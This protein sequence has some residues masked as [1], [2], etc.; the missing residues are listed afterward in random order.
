M[1]Q[2]QPVAKASPAL[3]ARSLV[4]LVLLLSTAATARGQLTSCPKVSQVSGLKIMLD[5]VYVDASATS[6]VP[7]VSMDRLNSTVSRRLTELRA[8]L[9]NPPEIVLC[10]GRRPRTASDFVETQVDQLNARDV[11]LEVW[12]V[13]QPSGTSAASA[14]QATVGF[15][16]IPLR[17]YEHFGNTAAD[18]PG[19]YLADY[20]LQASAPDNWLAQSNEFRAYVA[21]GLGVKA[22]RLTDYDRSQRLFCRAQYLLQPGGV[23]PSDPEQVALLEYTLK[24]AKAVVATARAAPG[25]NGALKAIDPAVAAACGQ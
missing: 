12:G 6:A 24:M 20:T 15:A 10:D 23:P 17:Y 4:F 25:Y 9:G 8:E 2:L 7:R 1:K 19:V 11:V 13:L 18:I 21:I 5:G 14:S 22:F 16:V 3:D